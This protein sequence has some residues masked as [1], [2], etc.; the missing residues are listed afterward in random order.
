MGDRFHRAA[1]DGSS[2][3]GKALLKE[4]TSR[5]LD[6]RD[7]EGMTPTLIAAQEGHSEALMICIQR[8]GKPN[9]YNAIGQTALH[10]ATDRGHFR[11]VDYICKYYE[12]DLVKILFMMDLAGNTAKMLAT[13]QGHKKLIAL[14]DRN[15][16]ELLKRNP[17][18]VKKYKDKAKKEMEVCKKKYNKI[19]AKHKTAKQSSSAPAKKTVYGETSV[20]TKTTD[21][22]STGFLGTFT[23]GK[24][25][26][27]VRRKEMLDQFDFSAMDEVDGTM[28]VSSNKNVLFGQGTVKNTTKNGTSKARPDVRDIFGQNGDLDGD[29]AENGELGTVSAVGMISTNRFFFNNNALAEQFDVL[30]ATTTT[31]ATFIDKNEE[32]DSD[33][34]LIESDDDEEETS[35][36]LEN[37][38]AALGLNDY[39]DL[40]KKEQMDI[41]AVMM[42][43]DADLRAL[44]VPLGPRIKIL[45][46]MDSRRA[47]MA[48]MQEAASDEP[49]TH[50]F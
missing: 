23:M 10:L 25:I 32:S 47:A 46:T 8:G 24:R 33:D 34:S 9:L 21:G 42:S 29:L 49:E 44:G 17:K 15:E 28:T 13:T 22:S 14:L 4:A 16:A 5:D 40:F 12:E 36:P 3:Q 1:K 38:L 18:K 30:G 48:S 41:E 20:T 45:K 39:W 19:M 7:K 27:T 43:T 50:A 31:G 35:D 6:R 37:F 2:P 26:G 11:I